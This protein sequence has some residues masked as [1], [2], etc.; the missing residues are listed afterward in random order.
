M[1]NI[2]H[3]L[4]GLAVRDLAPKNLF[5]SK[6]FLWVAILIASAPDIDILAWFFG[7]DAYFRFHRGI[8]HSVFLIPFWGFLGALIVYYASRKKVSF[9]KSGLWYSMIIVVHLTMDWVTS[10]GTELFAPFTHK[11]Y[12]ANLFPIVDLWIILPLSL[13]S[14]IGKFYNDR[15]RTFSIGVLI[16]LIFLTGF[17][18]FSKMRSESLIIERYGHSDKI[19][20][21]ADIESWREWLNPSIYRVVT[22]HGDSAISYKVVPHTGN[23]ICQ[24]SFDLFSTDDEYWDEAYRY[25]LSKNYLDRSELPIAGVLGDR[26]LISDLRYTSELASNSSLTVYFPLI[27]DT[28]SGPPKMLRPEPQSR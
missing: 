12:S 21:F 17:R 28:I 13:L 6:A 20:S 15:R 11:T 23:V 18:L 2:A 24:N 26:F 14:F 7:Q 4:S 1:D 27:G 22:V 3:T 25:N 5:K 16:F 19:V 10:Y 8:T 9:V